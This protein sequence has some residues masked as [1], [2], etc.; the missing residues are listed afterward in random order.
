VIFT[1]KEVSSG[2][3]SGTLGISRK[4]ILLSGFS[5]WKNLENAARSIGRRGKNRERGLR[6]VSPFAFHARL[7]F[8]TVLF[9]EDLIAVLEDVGEYGLF[10]SNVNVFNLLSFR[11]AD[12]PEARCPRHNVHGWRVIDF[13]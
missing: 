7:R 1:I 9:R 3:H 4:E 11:G 13:D 2:T 8:P 6:Y 5:Y 10:H 12:T